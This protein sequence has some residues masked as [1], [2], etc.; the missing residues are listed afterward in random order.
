MQ[1]PCRRH[2]HR[3]SVLHGGISSALLCLYVT[4]SCTQL[5]CSSLQ[6]QHIS[7]C[8]ALAREHHELSLACTAHV[9]WLCLHPCRVATQLLDQTAH[10]QDSSTYHTLLGEVKSEQRI[11]AG[12]AATAQQHHTQFHECLACMSAEHFI[13]RAL[14]GCFALSPARTCCHVVCR[15]ELLYQ[16]LAHVGH[17]VLCAGIPRWHHIMD[18]GP[19]GHLHLRSLRHRS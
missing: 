18:S 9:S 3:W 5:Q 7:A 16:L 17:T 13:M 10:D 4:I 15:A 19:G 1:R 8:T 12:V 6:V 11:C 2:G 14:Q